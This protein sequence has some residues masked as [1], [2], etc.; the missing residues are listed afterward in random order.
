MKFTY[1][2]V[3]KANESERII[4]AGVTTLKVLELLASLDLRLSDELNSLPIENF[5]YQPIKP[6]EN[7]TSKEK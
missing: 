4:F 2:V 7:E 5:I 1:Q 3:F 6:N